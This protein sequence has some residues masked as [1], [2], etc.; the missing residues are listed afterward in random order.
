[1]LAS[2]VGGT[3]RKETEMNRFVDDLMNKMT[4]EEKV[5]QL[6]LVSVG[7]DITGPILSENVEEKIKA[8]QVGECSIL[9]HPLQCASC[10]IS[11]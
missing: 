11:P 7:F 3:D 4:L 6:N 2:C 1:M 5:G 10:R 8:G 9:L